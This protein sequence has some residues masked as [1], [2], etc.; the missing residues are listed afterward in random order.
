MA[1]RCESREVWDGPPRCVK[2]E[3]DLTR[4]WNK[5][6]GHSPSCSVRTSV[7]FF[8]NNIHGLLVLV[9]DYYL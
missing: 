9:S 2:I 7:S 1:K 6:G 8:L 3:Q 4:G 5:T